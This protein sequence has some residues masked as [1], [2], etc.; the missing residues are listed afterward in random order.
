MNRLIPLI[1]LVPLMLL[2]SGCA[3]LQGD[4][5]RNLAQ[6]FLVL[7]LVENSSQPAERAAGAR[8]IMDASEQLLD[9]DPT[10]TVD[11]LEAAVRASIEW[12]NYPASEALVID[13]L[14]DAARAD[15]DQRVG[16]VEGL[17]DGPR[18]ARILEIFDQIRG[19]L[20]MTGY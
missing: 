12:Q 6:T 4:A 1:L 13:A 2:S 15:L 7:K 19:A 17:F 10:L 3:T 9:R 16:P 14:I 20:A 11:H 5:G 8:R 18:R